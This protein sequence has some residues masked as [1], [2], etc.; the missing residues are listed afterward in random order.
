[1]TRRAFF[2]GMAVACAICGLTYFNDAVLRQ[3]FLIGNFVPI[4]VYGGL[5]LF[6]VLN[7]VLGRFFPRLAFSG[8]EVVVVLAMS[9]AVC[10]I[11]GTNLMRKFTASVMLP[12]HLE[13]SQPGWVE[14]RV[15][16]WVPAKMLADPGAVG[17]SALDSFVLGRD[18]SRQAHGR[19]VIPWRAWVSTLAFW[20]PLILVL[21]FS[22]FGLALVVHRQWSE[23][24][25]LSYPLAK[26]INAFIG[27]APQAGEKGV[28]H[29]RRFW[30]A[31]LIV[32]LFH[33]NNYLF[34]WFPGWIEVPRKF[35]F[36]AVIQAYP[37]LLEVVAWMPT[38]AEPT[39]Y[40]SVVAIG[41][42]L[43]REISFSMGFGPYL[44]TMAC[45]LLAKMGVF[46][47][48]SSNVNLKDHFFSA[49]A[50]LGLFG[51]VVFL[52]W[53]HYR[54]V[55]LRA[56]R[57][58][59][60][61]DVH[62]YEKWGARLFVS[63]LVIFILMLRGVNVDWQIGTLVTL[64]LVVTFVVMSRVLAETGLYYMQTQ[65]SPSAVIIILLGYPALGVQL[66][67]VL[68][69]LLIVLHASPRE[70]F[71][72]FAVSGLKLL[73]DY[74]VRFS[75]ATVAIAVAV[76]A[77]MGVAIV[78]TLYFQYSHGVNVADLWATLGVPRAA[79]LI[80]IEA[81]QAIEAVGLATMDTPS[82]WS[83]FLHA[84]H[85]PF[86]WWTLAAGFSALLLFCVCRLRFSWWPFHPAMLL[87]FHTPHLAFFAPSFLL[88][89]LLKLAVSK[90]GGAQFQSTLGVVALGLFAGE[91]LAALFISVSGWA[92]Y[93]VTGEVPTLYQILPFR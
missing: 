3:N 46:Q 19:Q 14:N 31:A 30:V 53:H 12:H 51:V 42:L 75:G 29:D 40:F 49:G 54:R 33:L 56:F 10:A 87:F 1:M 78:A 59:R 2:S 36:S 60:I 76:C 44:Y 58:S 84:A 13:R 89:G 28:L 8:Q 63:G 52:G 70:A 47:A 65:W 25:R 18:T 68:T 15:L 67:T 86:Q 6:L 37:S 79:F 92:F 62:S 90:Y 80:G 17:P 50:G 93:G 20:L 88:G 57:F 61:T 22:L 77:G 43:S 23:H 5:L 73:S 71:M 55:F 39:V 41:Y 38:L 32:V 11:P 74:R 45:V 69:L 66:A 82:G 85:E 24:E 4:V 91:I 83:R 26:I 21:W 27:Q 9:L 34:A 35:D 64:L 48:Q 7:P 16:E 72:P 81:K